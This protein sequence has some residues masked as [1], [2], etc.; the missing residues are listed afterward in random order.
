MNDLISIPKAELEQLRMHVTEALKI[1]DRYQL[2]ST[3]PAPVKKLSKRE[4][5]INYYSQKLNEKRKK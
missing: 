2:T 5:R 4:E 1:I 3:E